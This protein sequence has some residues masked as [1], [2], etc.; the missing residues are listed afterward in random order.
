VTVLH[1]L[2]ESKQHTRTCHMPG[3]PHVRGDAT[4]ALTM[5][6]E[7]YTSLAAFDCCEIL[8]SLF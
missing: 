8:T 2:Q 3:V 6:V 4:P 5:A 7:S 1:I